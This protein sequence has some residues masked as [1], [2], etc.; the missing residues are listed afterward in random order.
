VKSRLKPLAG[1]YTRLLASGNIETA[2]AK[3]IELD[4]VRTLPGHRH[5]GSTGAAGVGPLRR[6]L[7]AYS[8][9]DPEV[10]YCQVFCPVSVSVSTIVNS[11]VISGKNSLLVT[12]QIKIFKGL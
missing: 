1:H 4:I 2:A 7:L 3:Q 8:R 11:L 6:V 5:F 9:Y 12:I 10:G